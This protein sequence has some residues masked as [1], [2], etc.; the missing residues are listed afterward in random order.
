M[1]MRWLRSGSFRSHVPARLAGVVTLAVLCSLAGVCTLAQPARAS[2]Q[3]CGTG[4]G[5][6]GFGGVTAIASN[7]AGDYTLIPG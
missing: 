6:I 5:Q 2:C 3:P 7:T 4:P 1:V